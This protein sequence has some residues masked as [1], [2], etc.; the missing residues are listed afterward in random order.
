MGKLYLLGGGLLIASIVFLAAI[1]LRSNTPETT[2]PSTGAESAGFGVFQAP[3]NV[4]ESFQ[5]NTDQKPQILSQQHNTQTVLDDEEQA[6]KISALIRQWEATATSTNLQT[7]AQPAITPEQSAEIVRRQSEQEEITD[8]FNDLLGTKTTDVLDRALGTS[9]GGSSFGSQDIWL[10][11]YNDTTR[12]Q[13][14]LNT[15][16]QT[17]TQQALHT[18]GNTLGKSFKAFLLAQGDQTALLERF[19]KDRADTRA[20][21][22][23]TDAYQLFSREL[24]TLEAPA[25]VQDTHQGLV[26]S[27]SDIGTYLWRLTDATSDQEL[28]TK[29]LEY[30]TISETVAKHHVTIIT[31]FKA[32]GVEFKSHEPGSIFTFSPPN[33]KNFSL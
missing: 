17:P 4:F 18:Y 29:M 28:L 31:L 9:G 1:T 25:L 14:P 7:R 19:L 5:R 20:L 10:G 30:N 2:T 23:L 16:S 33:N 26:R 11:E 8:I 21:K 13:E 15:V 6:A 24:A 32:H 27:Y 22:N 12:P 3:Q